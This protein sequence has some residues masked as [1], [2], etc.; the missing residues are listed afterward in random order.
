MSKKNIRD[1]IRN[2]LSEEEQAIA[3]SFTD[4]LE[5]NK[6]EFIKDNGYWKGKIYYLINWQGKGVCY[7]AIKDPEEPNNHWTVWSDD[8]GSKWLEANDV[9][10][11]IKSVA[12]NHIGHC[13]NCG[14]CDGGKPKTVF[15]KVFDKVCGCTFRI[16]NPNEDDLEFMK[17][18]VDIRMKE[19]EE[20]LGD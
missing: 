18:M 9:D 20:T 13:G 2:E 11:N 3:I 10:N 1:Y 7:I 5:E 8:M 6:M 14:S 16:D 19:I 12:W 4:Y 15:G 17:K